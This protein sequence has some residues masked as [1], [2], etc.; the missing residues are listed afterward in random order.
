MKKVDEKKLLVSIIGLIS[1]LQNEAISVDECGAY[2]FKPGTITNLNML[3]CNENILEILEECLFIEDIY[4]TKELNDLLNKLKTEAVDELKKYNELVYDNWDDVITKSDSDL[5]ELLSMRGEKI[6]D[7][8]EM[9][10][11]IHVVFDKESRVV[12]TGEYCKIIFEAFDSSFVKD[13]IL[14]GFSDSFNDWKETKTMTK[15]NTVEILKNNYLILKD[16]TVET[17]STTFVVDVIPRN[18]TNE[19]QTMRIKIWSRICHCNWV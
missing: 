3:S 9:N 17:T 10:N 16:L 8:Y 13:C 19:K 14:F 12:N 5:V 7:F 4:D 2:L 15:T 18:G 6:K 1:S 11:Q